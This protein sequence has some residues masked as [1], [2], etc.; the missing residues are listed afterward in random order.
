MALQ[1]S[2]A[3]SDGIRRTV[4]RTGGI[5]FLGFLAIQFGLQISANSAVLG[6]IPPQAAEQ[7]SQA[8]GITLPIPGS[9]SVVLFVSLMILSATYFVIL[10]RTFAQSP[11][12]MSRFPASLSQQLGQTT[13][14][15]LVGGLIITVSI[16]FGTVLLIFPGLF[17]AASFL[18]FIFAVAVEERGIISSLKRSWDL[19]RG[20]RLKLG[21]LVVMSAIFGGVI[22]TITPLLTLAGLPIVAD[23]VTVVLTAA[24]FVPYYATI[25]SAYL[26]LRD[27]EDDQNHPEQNPVDVSQTPKSI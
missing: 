1:L 13:I 20:S 7:F 17:L 15:A 5:L 25:A 12:E 3:I 14:F 26:Q 18:F 10:S 11:S 9:V 21:I 27:Q 6:L 23:V 4:S 22:G 2:H 19:A 24:F 8:A 16:M